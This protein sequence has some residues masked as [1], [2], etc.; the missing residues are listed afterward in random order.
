M[1]RIVCLTVAVLLCVAVVCPVFAAEDT[2]VPSITY[3]DGPDIDDA[4]LGGEDAGGKVDQ[5]IVVTSIIEAEEKTTDIPQESR[6]LLI[7]VYEKLSD[8]TVKLPLEGDYVIRELVDLSFKQSTCIED[9][10]IH[11]EEL[12]KEGVT[13]TVTFDLGVSADT[14]VVVMSFHDGKWDHVESVVNNGDGTVT[15][16]H[17]H[18]CPVAFL[19]KAEKADEP[20]KTGDTVGQG[21]LLWTILMAASL[22]AVVTVFTKCRK[23]VK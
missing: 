23:F 10:H 21:L 2:F 18:F 3:K 11:E 20:S 13:V 6:D 9:D 16:V 12:N 4:V 8:G 5:C 19:V 1:R 22:A 17:E 7:E 14:E 15:C